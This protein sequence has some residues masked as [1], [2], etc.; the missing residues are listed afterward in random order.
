LLFGGVSLIGMVG[1]AG[2]GC[3]I[4]NATGGGDAGPAVA[5]GSDSPDAAGGGGDAGGGGSDAS[6]PDGSA[7]DASTGDGSSGSADCP[8]PPPSKPS[9]DVSGNGSFATALHFELS[10]VGKATLAS[11]TDVHFYSL[12]LP[13]C[14]QDGVLTVSVTQTA[15][16]RTHI[17]LY[18]DAK[19]QLTD[20]LASDRTTSP[21]NFTFGATAGKTYLF[22][23]GNAY[24]NVSGTLPYQVTA[25]YAPV[26]DAHERND[27]FDQATP[28][29]SGTF[30]FYVFA[31]DQT[32]K[33]ADIDF[34]S[35]TAPASAKKMHVHIDNKSPSTEGQRIQAFLFDGSKNHLTDVLGSGQQADVDAVW[36]LPAG[37]GNFFVALTTAYP[38]SNSTTAS[39]ATLTFE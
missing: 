31:G 23:V 11:D 32:N 14:S 22:T 27:T 9:V 20:A 8:I 3:T 28:A 2:A 6:A 24:N 16:I 19:T 37:G 29:P 38:Y 13:A 10:Q 26:P 39:R 1:F 21:F 7:G 4:A 15:D 18:N 33:G 17:V 12:T 36:D 35:V 25:T 34:F 5:P 30:D